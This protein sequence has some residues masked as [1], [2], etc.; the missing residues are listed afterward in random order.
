M[1]CVVQC[2]RRV[3][4]AP[5]NT[6]CAGGG[7]RRRRGHSGGAGGGANPAPRAQCCA[8]WHHS[9]TV[10]TCSAPPTTNC[11]PSPTASRCARPSRVSVSRCAIRNA[12]PTRSARPNLTGAR[13]ATRSS[14]CP[15]ASAIASTATRWRPVPATCC[16]SR[17]GDLTATSPAS[18]APS[19]YAMC[20]RIRVVER[21]LK[22]VRPE[23]LHQASL[24]SGLLVSVVRREG[25]RTSEAGDQAPSSDPAVSVGPVA[26]THDRPAPSLGQAL[27]DR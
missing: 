22:T 27:P 19:R 13:P 6:A 23:P 1:A 5:Q 4:H 26:A 8:A 7:K 25:R 20:D 10:P 21:F 12:R 15:A 3:V 2:P 24:F 14:S 11:A 18:S 17:P 16:I 9:P